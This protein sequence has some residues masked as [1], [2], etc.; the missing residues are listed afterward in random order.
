MYIGKAAAVQMY[1]AS[2]L[3]A[4]ILVTMPETASLLEVLATVVHDKSS[5]STVSVLSALQQPDLW[6]L[7]PVCP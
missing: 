6:S 2:A 7:L 3:S 1:T 4:Q 5:L